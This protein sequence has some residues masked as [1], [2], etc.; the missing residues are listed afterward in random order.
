MMPQRQNPAPPRSPP[1]PAS[2][3]GG[4]GLAL[5]SSSLAPFPP[6]CRDLVEKTLLEVRQ[7]S[8][9]AACGVR[10]C[11]DTGTRIST[12][13][14]PGGGGGRSLPCRR[15]VLPVVVP[16]VVLALRRG[17]IAG[18][19]RGVPNHDED[20]DRLD[21]GVDGR[22]QSPDAS[23]DGDG[24]DDRDTCEDVQRLNNIRR[25]LTSSA[26]VTT[27]TTTT[28]TTPP[29]APTTPIGTNDAA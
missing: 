17:S 15:A 29:A 8:Q 9:S 24:D 19:G 28:T 18:G 27:A 4:V 25:T 7:T 3:Y 5:L 1:L 22:R 12:W 21:G 6:V 20:R 26:T 10:E 14:A 16:V 13:H 11:W 23:R 2:A